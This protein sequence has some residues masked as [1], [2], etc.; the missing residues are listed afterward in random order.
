MTFFRCFIQNYRLSAVTVLNFCVSSD[1]PGPLRMYS[2]GLC[3]SFGTAVVG[4]T[5][6]AFLR[7][8]HG[9]FNG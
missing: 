8:A 1:F 4:I 5:V 9:D 3:K 7:K 2:A 6:A